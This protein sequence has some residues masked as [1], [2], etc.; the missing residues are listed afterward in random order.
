M[1]MENTSCRDFSEWKMENQAMTFLKRAGKN[2]KQ[3][4]MRGATDIIKSGKVIRK[5]RIVS[6]RG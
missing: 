1:G 6:M 3:H 5:E 2:K 4:S